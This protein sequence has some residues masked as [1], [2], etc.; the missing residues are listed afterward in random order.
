VLREAV[1]QLIGRVDAGAPNGTL[2][3][4]PTPVLPADYADELSRRSAQ[5]R[6]T[7]ETLA[8]APDGEVAAW[9][10]VVVPPNAERAAEV[11]GTYV[12]PAHRGRGLGAAVKAACLA[13][14]R[15]P[16]RVHRVTTSSD[17]ANRWM[18]AINDLLGFRPVE[19]E[20]IFEARVHP[21]RR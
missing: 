3:W 21:T 13:H 2:A 7:V 17:D 18:R 8:L 9:T 10:G 19:V 11:E 12:E 16:L 1:G 5:G 4:E 14:L 20:A 6:I 15:D